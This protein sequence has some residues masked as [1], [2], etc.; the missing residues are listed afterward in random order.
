MKTP[1]LLL[2]AMLFFTGAMPA[3]ARDRR[4]QKVDESEKPPFVGMTK[5][6]AIARYG[7]P[8]THTV[9][10]QG[11]QWIYLLNFGEVMGKAFI[12]FHFNPTPLRTAVL[13]FGADG[14]VKT[15]R[16]DA[17]PKN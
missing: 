14:R 9:T 17:E 15:F 8:R 3:S 7:E 6:Q 1:T 4:A 2:A 10:E 5:A 13:T 16:W 11:E 12:P